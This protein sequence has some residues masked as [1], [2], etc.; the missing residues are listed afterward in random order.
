MNQKKGTRVIWSFGLVCAPQRCRDFTNSLCSNSIKSFYGIFSG[1]QQIPMGK[2]CKHGPS[3]ANQ[4]SEPA[5]LRNRA[6]WARIFILRKS[7]P[8]ATK[9]GKTKRRKSSPVLQICSFETSK[10]TPVCKK[11]Q[12]GEDGVLVN[13]YYFS[14]PTRALTPSL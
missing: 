1:D 7:S 11:G 2:V 4:V 13:S 14:M 8:G 5:R 10:H 6:L 12:T 3:R 9:P